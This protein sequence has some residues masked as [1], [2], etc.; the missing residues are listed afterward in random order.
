[1]KHGYTCPMVRELWN[2][3]INS[4]MSILVLGFSHSSIIDSLQKHNSIKQKIILHKCKT[5]IILWSVTNYF[6]KTDWPKRCQLRPL[7]FLSRDIPPTLGTI[8][9]FFGILGRLSFLLRG[10]CHFWANVTHSAPKISI[11]T[12]IQWRRDLAAEFLTAPS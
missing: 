10:D 12:T 4:G 1:M 5:Q 8:K 6:F 9:Y 3:M 11:Q 2:L 7:V